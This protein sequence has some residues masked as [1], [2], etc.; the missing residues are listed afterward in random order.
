MANILESL[1]VHEQIL[2]FMGYTA[3]LF[4]QEFLENGISRILNGDK[5]IGYIEKGSKLH[6]VIHDEVVNMNCYNGMT[7]TIEP[8]Y[9]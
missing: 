4:S 5:E 6:V 9:I 7:S 2:G 3:D 8:V 1:E